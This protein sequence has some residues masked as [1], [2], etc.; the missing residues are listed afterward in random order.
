M[1]VASSPIAGRRAESA[2]LLNLPVG[3]AVGTSLARLKRRPE[4][5]RAAS[6]G[7]KC[8]TPGLIL[9]ARPHSA[10]ERDAI[11]SRRVGFTVSRKVGNAVVR[12]RVRRRLRHL[13]EHIMTDHAT[14]ACDYVL[15]GRQATVGR[16]FPDLERDLEKALK[17]LNAYREG[18]SALPVAPNGA[19]A[20]IGI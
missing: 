13:A 17:K 14:G 18:G 4:F 19:D 3:Y 1:D 16:A 15:I 9:Q 8:V 11:P 6:A 10:G 20:E 5:L 2:C 7:N 12:N